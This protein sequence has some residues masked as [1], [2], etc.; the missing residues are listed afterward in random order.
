M[1]INALAAR[2]TSE[3]ATRLGAQPFLA[4]DQASLRG[5]ARMA[6]I[7]PPLAISAISKHMDLFSS[8]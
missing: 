6:A 4:V 2:P 7:A 3:E 8:K 1:L 5:E